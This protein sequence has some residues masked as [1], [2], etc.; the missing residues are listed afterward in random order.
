MSRANDIPNDLRPLDLARG[1][2]ISADGRVFNERTRREARPITLS[3]ARRFAT[4][5]LRFDPKRLREIG[6]PSADELLCEEVVAVRFRPG[7][8]ERIA[9][10]AQVARWVRIVPPDD[11]C[12]DLGP[13]GELAWRRDH[14][15]GRIE[16]IEES[17]YSPPCEISGGSFPAHGD[18]GKHWYYIATDATD[19]RC[20]ARVLMHGPSLAHKLFTGA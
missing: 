15:D 8:P 2:L 19:P 17:A 13:D 18:T 4:A 5:D 9:E 10:V 1:Y 7:S 3:H 6:G 12:L 20:R 11:V 16:W 14:A